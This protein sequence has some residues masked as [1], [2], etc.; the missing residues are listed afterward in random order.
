STTTSLQIYDNTANAWE[1]L[2][3]NSSPTAGSDF[4]L[5]GD[6][7]GTKYY[8]GSNIASARLVTGTTT[9]VTT[10]KT[11]QITIQFTP[12]G[13]TQRNHIFLNDDQGDVNSYTKSHSAATSSS[14]SN[15]KI[16]ERLIA[17]IQID[18][19]GTGTSTAQW[20]LQF[21][22]NDGVWKD[23]ATTTEIRWSP[24]GKGA[25]WGRPGGVPLASRQV[26]ATCSASAAYQEGRFTAGTATSTAFG[27]GPSKC[28]ELAYAIETSGAALNQTY[29]LR[30][31]DGTANTALNTYAVRK[32]WMIRLM[33]GSIHLL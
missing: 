25:L 8:D 14:I 9:Q 6:V 17:R 11:D 19:T 32:L 20:R 26:T 5:T 28:T 2:Q 12:A 7:S 24:S 21:D 23:L 22:K 1:T 31:I 29:R 4:T 3:T 13:I 30:V 27:I 15:V 18:N 33:L 16:G 10:L